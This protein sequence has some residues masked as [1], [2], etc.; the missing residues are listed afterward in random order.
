[1]KII[2]L[3]RCDETLDS[4]ASL[5]YDGQR[6]YKGPFRRNLFWELFFFFVAESMLPV[7]F[8][9]PVSNDG[10]SGVSGFN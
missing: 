8:P 5:S 1:M 6:C 3:P 4:S 7:R 2:F 10:R 9:K